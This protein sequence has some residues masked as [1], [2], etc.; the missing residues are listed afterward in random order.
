MLNFVGQYIF[1]KNIPLCTVLVLINKQHLYKN[2]G[3]FLFIVSGARMSAV[4]NG[5]GHKGSPVR[6]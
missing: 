5:Y 3:G 1:R 2:S 6:M 4:V